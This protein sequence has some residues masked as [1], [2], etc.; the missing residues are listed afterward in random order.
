MLEGRRR[1][2]VSAKMRVGKFEGG[3]QD[4]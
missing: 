2:P 1:S 3:E 4:G